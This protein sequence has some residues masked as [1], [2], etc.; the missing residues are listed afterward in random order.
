MSLI[1][2][3]PSPPKYLLNGNLT[4]RNVYF[5][6]SFVVMVQDGFQLIDK[7]NKHIFRILNDAAPYIIPS[8]IGDLE[9]Y[10][11][12][13]SNEDVENNFLNSEL[14]GNLSKLSSFSSV[15]VILSKES[16]HIEIS[17]YSLIHTVIT[18]LNKFLIHYKLLTHKYYIPII[19]VS[20]IMRYF[21][22]EVF[23]N[24]LTKHR[25]VHFFHDGPIPFTHTL[26]K[27]N[28]SLLREK[29][30]DNKEVE[31]A[32]K[33]NN[34]ILTK[35]YLEDYRMVIIECTI[36]FESWIVP[37]LKSVYKEKHN[38]SNNR[39][40]KLF[41][42]SYID[43]KGDKIYS[44]VFIS[45]MIDKM[46][47]EATGFPFHLKP[48]YTVLKETI[49]LRNYLVHGKKKDA[50]TKEQADKAVFIIN[51]CIKLITEAYMYYR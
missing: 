4:N 24:G 46:I 15:L 39:I 38:L 12:K 2:Q 23:D 16:N 50:V 26:D 7:E 11:H 43:E 5:D 48:E 9:F 13:N 37:F 3:F 28:E 36:K 17:N 30:K 34:E 32:A 25:V 20:S 19:T 33:M 8:E 31:F 49:N 22:N 27:E 18:S 41:Q 40:E 42:K 47:Y 6:L 29:L 10:F 51:Y 44:P 21:F 35:V 1:N 45:D 14:V